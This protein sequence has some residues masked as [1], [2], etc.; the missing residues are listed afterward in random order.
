[1]CIGICA[2]DQDVLSIAMLNIF[3]RLELFGSKEEA[4]D[5]RRKGRKSLFLVTVDGR[6]LRSGWLAPY[7]EV[8]GAG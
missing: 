2:L 4:D 5:D 8:G 3:A 1:M 7:R 6:G